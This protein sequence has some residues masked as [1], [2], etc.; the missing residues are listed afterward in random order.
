MDKRVWD[1]AYR[2]AADPVPVPQ[3]SPEG[4]DLLKGRDGHRMSIGSAKRH[5]R[6]DH[7]ESPAYANEERFYTRILD[8][9][10]L[11]LLR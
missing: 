9:S 4:V 7:R 11:R 1:E 8:S 6:E 2:R 3:E 10:L 5:G